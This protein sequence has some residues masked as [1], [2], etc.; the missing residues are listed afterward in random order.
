MKQEHYLEYH[1][2]PIICGNE[3]SAIMITVEDVTEQ[4]LSD[5]KIKSLL[6]EKEL[7][8][9]EVHHRIKNNMASVESLLRLQYDSI[10][11]K[12]CQSILIDASSRVSSMRVLYDRLFQ[13]GDFIETS[14]EAYFSTLIDE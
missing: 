8:L 9:R 12:K 10:D 13:S 11:N 3:I 14:F 1:I 4:K 2:I 5:I 6:K 7:L